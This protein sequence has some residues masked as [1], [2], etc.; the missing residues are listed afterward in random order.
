ME[1]RYKIQNI[2][3]AYKDA[4]V[5]LKWRAM[6]IKELMLTDEQAERFK[7]ARSAFKVLVPEME[8][9]DEKPK[10]KGRNEK[11]EVTDV[12]D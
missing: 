3:G 4:I 6:E 7:A 10:A 8:R 12:D 11:K 1:K 2:I 9:P 5:G